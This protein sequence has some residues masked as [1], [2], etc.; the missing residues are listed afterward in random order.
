MSNDI[1]DLSVNV[2]PKDSL[3]RKIKHD[4]TFGAPLVTMMACLLINKILLYIL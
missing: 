4:V 3:P 2:T 1:I